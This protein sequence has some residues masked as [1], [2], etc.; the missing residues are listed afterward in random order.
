M[1]DLTVV[2]GSASGS[3]IPIPLEGLV[4]GREADALGRLGGDLSLSRR[5]ARFIRTESGH[6]LVEDLRSTNGTYVNG[7]RIAGPVLLNEGDTIIVGDTYLQFGDTRLEP[8]DETLSGVAARRGVAIGGSVHA[9]HG[10]IGAIGD[11]TGDVD[12]SR[13]YDYDA[14]GLGLYVRARGAAR[15]VLVL[16]TLIGFVGFG[17]AGY[18]IV[19]GFINAAENTSREASRSAGDE[20]SFTPWLPLGIAL[21]FTGMVITTIGLFMI[22]DER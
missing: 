18:P 3:H 7:L 16:G 11:V 6:V 20:F 13:R 4:V 1:P 5:H 15:F 21:F 22:R 10:S 9:E 17:L 12:L 8:H 19:Q 14:S 2:S